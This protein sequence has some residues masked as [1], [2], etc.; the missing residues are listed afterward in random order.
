MGGIA[1]HTPTGG[2]V[3]RFRMLLFWIPLVKLLS[4]IT[5]YVSESGSQ[6]IIILLNERIRKKNQIIFLSLCRIG[7]T[8]CLM[9]YAIYQGIQIPYLMWYDNVPFNL[10]T[11]LNLIIQ[12]CIFCFCESQPH[13]FHLT[14]KL[15]H[16]RFSSYLLCTLLLFPLHFLSS[17][18]HPTG[19]S[20][21]LFPA[22]LPFLRRC[23][24]TTTTLSYN[25]NYIIV[26]YYIHL[27]SYL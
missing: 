5:A 12:R 9:W 21:C 18:V 26:D 6:T 13:K 2:L 10:L 8:R 19:F 3:P 23:H 22:S 17:P 24:R 16:R 15:K 7:P 4:G 14:S 25:R 11:N 1:L 20:F 27:F